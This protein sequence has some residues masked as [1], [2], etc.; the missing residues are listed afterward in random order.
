MKVR[1]ARTMVTA[2]ALTKTNSRTPGEQWSGKPCAWRDAAEI[3]IG[4]LFRSINAG[5]QNVVRR[6]D[7]VSFASEHHHAGSTVDTGPLYCASRLFP[8]NHKVGEL[9]IP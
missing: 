4:P 6:H 3:T 9:L 5:R 1:P 2:T 8:G 7:V